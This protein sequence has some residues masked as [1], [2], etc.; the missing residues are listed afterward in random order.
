MKPNAIFAMG[1]QIYEALP[2]DQVDDFMESTNLVRDSNWL[3][4][5]SGLGSQAKKN[6]L[7]IPNLISFSL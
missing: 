4:L 3:I 1:G 6:F 5:H 2:Q 7:F